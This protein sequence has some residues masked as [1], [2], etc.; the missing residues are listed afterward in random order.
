MNISMEKILKSLNPKNP[1]SDSGVKLNYKK[2]SNKIKPA[3]L[4]MAGLLFI[5]VFIEII[6][7]LPDLKPFSKVVIASDGTV[8]SAYLTRDDKWRLRCNLD[9]VSP[10]LVKAII[11]KEDK[12]FYWHPGVNPIAIL[13][14]FITNII[15]G[16]R[17]SGA[18]TITMQL[19]RMLSPSDRTYLNKIIEIFRA[20]QIELHYSKKTILEMYLNSLPYGGNIEGVKSASYIYFNRPP[21]KLSLAQSILLTVIP[22]DPNLYRIDKSVSSAKTKRNYWIKQFAKDKVFS[23]NSLHDALYE[24]IETARFNIPSNAPHFCY[25]IISNFHGDNIQTTLELDKQKKA[26]SLLSSYVERNKPKGISNGA[27]IVIDN[28]NSHVVAYCGSSDF[29]NQSASGQVNGIRAVRSPG[30]TLKAGLYA[31]AFDL[32][33][34][35]PKMKLL[36]VPTDFSGYEPENYSE[37]FHGEVTAEFALMNSLNV[38][39]V[40]LLEKVGLSQFLLLLEKAGFS[41]IIKQKEKL[42]LSMILGG[43]GVRM[44]QLAAMYSAFAREGRLYPSYYIKGENNGNYVQIFSPGAVYIVSQI[45]SNIKRPDFPN[46]L[47]NR[48][49]L[50]KIAWKTGTSYG[51]KDAWAVGYNPDYTIAVW[52]GNFDGKGSPHLSGSEMAVPLLFDLFNA[53][54]YNPKKKWIKRPTEVEYR[55]VCVETGNIPSKNCEQITS[56]YYIKNIST[57]NVCCLYKEFF[58]SFDESIQYCTE[59][60]PDTGY[61]KVLY[62]VYDPEIVLWNTLNNVEYKRI[63]AHNPNCQAKFSDEGPK[64]ISPSN[65]F[66][67]YIEDKSEQQILLQAA[68]G[69]DVQILYWYINDKFF[70]KSK[71]EEKQ[72]FNA[73]KGKIKITCL[74]DKGRSSTVFINVKVY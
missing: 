74:D 26:E 6:F 46:E 25:Y 10:D 21:G 30:S 7:P 61:K 3:L 39:A 48:T 36:D 38:P 62:P 4:S 1:N 56:D 11:E 24:P 45:L 47:L 32:G 63:P 71:T 2:Y 35:T 43:C 44:E 54:D 5:F 34:L 66:E 22:N 37:K 15:K 23:S 12:W 29:Y 13:R 52:M 60:L 17:V 18:S 72:F 27:V 31:Y 9:E 49:R 51:K 14:A 55:E 59:C 50:P 64:I 42:G 73:E 40:R 8:L 58:V 67:Y 33:I 69:E 41:D 53:I 16:E 57:N 70:I 20:L 65:N 68:G 28:S 19:A